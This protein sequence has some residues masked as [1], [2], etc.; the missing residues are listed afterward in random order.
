MHLLRM[1]FYSS[2]VILTF[3]TTS[4]ESMLAVCLAFQIKQ[5]TFEALGLFSF[6]LSGKGS[7]YGSWGQCVAARAACPA[8]SPGLLARAPVRDHLCVL[9][10]GEK[11]KVKQCHCSKGIANSSSE[12]LSGFNKE[13]IKYPHFMHIN[14]QRLNPLSHFWYF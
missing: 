13:F 8:G 14:L 6:T 10:E 11:E 1:S 12:W 3:L 5:V 2:S 4:V 7:K 9:H